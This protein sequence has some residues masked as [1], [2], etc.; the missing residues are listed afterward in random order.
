MFSTVAGGFAFSAKLGHEAKPGQANWM[1]AA[2][3]YVQDHRCSA[4]ASTD[5][6]L[7]RLTQ[8][9]FVLITGRLGAIYGHQKLLLL[10]SFIITVFSLC[11][12]FCNTYV[13]FVAVRALTGI[14]GGIIMPNAVATLTIMV[15]PG[16][17]RNI[18][19]AIF[20][21]TPPVGALVGALLVGAFLQYTEWKWHFILM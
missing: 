6:Y 11:N 7:D 15:P 12:A 19:L 13:S 9:A 16:K 14:G 8:S 17:A 5:W 1:A 20:A 4:I 10:G 2:Y 21:A 3:S 18:T